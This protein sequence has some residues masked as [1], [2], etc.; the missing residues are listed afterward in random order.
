MMLLK[1]FIAFAKTKLARFR[2]W[3]TNWLNDMYAASE[4]NVD[5]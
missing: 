1:R 4:W 2:V 5:E 3:L